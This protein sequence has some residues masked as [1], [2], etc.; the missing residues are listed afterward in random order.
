MNHNNATT[1][2]NAIF[3]AITQCSKFPCCQTMITLDCYVLVFFFDELKK[4]VCPSYEFRIRFHNYLIHQISINISFISVDTS[5][6]IVLVNV[7]FS[8]RER[9][10]R[11]FR[12]I[13]KSCLYI[14]GTVILFYLWCQ[15]ECPLFPS[16]RLYRF[17]SPL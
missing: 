1:P 7:T 12:C 8:G 4:R 10:F 14:F 5:I 9:P 2:Y 17:Q 3:T 16:A 13:S 15:L 6:T 11:L